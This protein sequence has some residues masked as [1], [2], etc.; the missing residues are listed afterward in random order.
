MVGAA[1]PRGKRL[2]PGNLAA[3]HVRS[4]FDVVDG[5]PAPAA[6]PYR[7]LGPVAGLALNVEPR[8]DRPDAPVAEIAMFIWTIC[9]G[10]VQT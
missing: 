10:I 8:R 2:N 9:T 1:P 7:E 6:E 5:E 4:E 3:F